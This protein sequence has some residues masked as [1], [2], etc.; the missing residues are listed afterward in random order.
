MRLYYGYLHL[1][2]QLK[3]ILWPSQLSI[4][5]LSIIN[6]MEIENLYSSIACNRHPTCLD[7]SEN[8]GIIY[9]ANH[10]V[11]YF[12]FD[13]LTGCKGLRT[14]VKHTSKVLT[15]KWIKS[16]KE[17]IFVSGSNDKTVIVW[18][19]L[20]SAAVT[21]VLKG[22]DGPVIAIDATTINNAIII[23]SSSA[24]NTLR[25][26]KSNCDT[27]KFVC[28]QTVFLPN[29]FCFAI[30]LFRFP[31]SNQVLMLFSEGEQLQLWAQ[32]IN[33]FS[34][35][36]NIVGHE[37]WIRCIDVID[38]E[39]NIMIL[40]GSQD[41]YA[42]VWKLHLKNHE[43]S[44]VPPQSIQMEEQIV[45][46]NDNDKQDITFS[47]SLESVIFGH[48]GWV[49]SA[50]FFKNRKIGIMTCSIDKSIIIWYQGNDGI[51]VDEHKIGEMGGDYLGFLGAKIS[52]N[53]NTIVA[54]GFQ[55]SIHIWTINDENGDIIRELT[56][57]GHFGGV[58]DIAWAPG[59]EF[60]FSVSTDQTTRIH[61]PF[62]SG[63][64]KEWHELARIQIHGYDLTSIAVLSPYVIATG[65]EEKVVRILKTTQHF[66]STLKA[67]CGLD[68]S[69]SNDDMSI[70]S[71][72][73]HASVPSL[74]LSSKVFLESLEDA[75]TV[76]PDTFHI[77]FEEDLIQNTLW[78]ETHKLYGHGYEICSLATSTGGKLLASSSRSASP[79]HSKIIIW[80]TISTKELQRL[81]GHSLTVTDL[82]FSPDNAYLLSTSRDRSWCIFKATGSLLKPFEFEAKGDKN[83]SP[84]TR[85]IWSCAWTFDSKIFATTSR[86]GTIATWIK[87]DDIN[88]DLKGWKL[89]TSISLE[90]ESITAISF[91]HIFYKDK[92]GEYLLAVGLQNGK[93]LIYNLSNILNHIITIEQ[94]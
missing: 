48:E 73:K 12:K 17:P 89:M 32:S 67:L 83:I 42:R 56:P 39:N 65:A 80:D 49:Y 27:L 21:H 18:C 66:I 28:F 9:G 14:F 51:W 64:T 82:K 7:Y 2:Q 85:I 57:T 31:V 43:M 69:T 5:N 29:Q 33:Q 50:Q 59:G 37:D 16:C 60:L 3:D 87:T 4:I 36:L 81:S 84:H 20:D 77:P 1:R 88:N 22:H 26:W 19:I 94:K 78:P 92:I 44:E 79:E 68:L 58:N 61:A 45:A 38:I 72:S 55:G 46:I 47:L 53:G 93:I 75:N 24:D 90:N 86:D 11:A 6:K 71:F 13:H 62:D 54:H 10:A 30:K 76:E 23:A 40:T 34:K 63:Y 52:S 15:L 41:N 8:F 70:K 35:V 25:L 91:S 74:G